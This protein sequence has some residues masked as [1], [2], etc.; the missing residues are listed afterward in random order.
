MENKK[1]TKKFE[2][3]LLVALGCFLIQAI[4]FGVA[5]NIHPQFLGYIIE[6]EGFALGAIS[7]M[8]TV[9]TIISAVFSP[10]IGKLFN[11][12]SA[13]LIYTIGAVISASGILLLSVAGDKLP[14]FYLGYGIAQIGAAA[15]SSIGI[16]VLVSSWF[17]DSIKGKVSG[18]IFAG[19]GL[20]NIFLQKLSASWI[21]S[22]GYQAAYQR[23]AILSVVVG[24]IVSILFI[25]M[26]KDKSEIMGRKESSEKENKENKVEEV[27]GYTFAEAKNLKAYWIFAIG[28]VF[29][30]IYVS[31]L[32]TQFSA[33]LKFEKFDADMLGTVGAVFAAASLVGNLMGGTLY[34]KLGSFKT[35]LIGFILATTACLSIM[36]A[37]KLQVLAFVFA[38]AK[39]LSVFA[40]IL[41][42]SMLTGALFG[43]KDFGTV[44]GITQVFFALGF[45]LGS[46]LFG[47]IVD[48][49]NY[50]AAWSF[51]L[52]AIFVAYTMLLS[53]IKA[54]NKLNKENDK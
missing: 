46:A 4:P 1:T 49:I 38:V 15:I 48:A 25:R 52:V 17:D 28:F 35:T 19:S 24:V 36:F 18:I 47:V 21:T 13:K 34:D 16:P 50:T 3:G 27:K 9:G 29:I 8:F 43:K 12:L 41:A 2:F 11:K 31:G 10:A 20:G 37:P 42:P 22:I 51:M 14:L 7:A 53:A 40:Y 45:A 5:S 44:L 39:G 30:G 32:A 54:M 23:F 6:K 26:P 33:Y